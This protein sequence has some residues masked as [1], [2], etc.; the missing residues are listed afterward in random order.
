MLCVVCMVGVCVIKY[1]VGIQRVYL[2]RYIYVIKNTIKG[3]KYIYFSL[4]KQ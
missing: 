2:L 1:L 3:L 4:F